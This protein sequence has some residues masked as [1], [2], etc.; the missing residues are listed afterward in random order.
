MKTWW[1]AL[2]VAFWSVFVV[3]IFF[4]IGGIIDV[5]RRADYEFQDADVSRVRWLL[6]LLA[7]GPFAGIA[8]YA[9][10]RRRL[11]RASG[12]DLL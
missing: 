12:E 11:R 5:A 2:E 10:P 4:Y 1:D 3:G 9:V 7:F 6:L 8:Y